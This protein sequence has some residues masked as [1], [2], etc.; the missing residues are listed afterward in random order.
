M[1]NASTIA[2][3]VNASD[4][5]LK[6]GEYPFPDLRIGDVEPA[7]SRDHH[8]LPRLDPMPNIIVTSPI[9]GETV[10]AVP[11][12]TAAE[13]RAAFAFA[14]RVQKSWAATPVSRRKEILLRYHDL[15]LDRQEELMDLIQAESGKNR[16]S[17][18]E[19]ILDQ[20]LTA[21]HYAY[22]AEKLLRPTRARGAVPVM[23]QVR[24]EHPPVGVVGMIAPWNYPLVLTASDALAAL[25]AGNA[26]VL[27]PDA[28]VPLSALRVAELL[29]EAGL[30]EGLFH[31]MTGS[32]EDVGQAIVAQC[33]YLMFTG[34]TRTGRKLAAQAAER[35]VGFSAELGGKNPMIVAADADIGKAARGAVTACFSNGGQLCISIERIYVHESVAAEFTRQFL[36]HTK[37]MKIGAGRD[38]RIELGSLISAAHRSKVEHMVDDAV[39]QGAR[40]LSGGRALPELG[41]AFYAPTVLVDVPPTATL[42]REEVF[43]PVVYLETVSSAAEAVA[44]ANDTDYGLNA[45]VWAK[46][47]TGRALASQ[48]QAGT[49]NINEG[50]AAAWS[51]MDAPMGGWK[52]SGVGRRHGAEGLLKYTESRTVAV[53][54]F[55]PLSGP[56]GVD[57]GRVAEVYRTA[58]KLGKRLLR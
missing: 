33:D 46:P 37:A 14:R 7:R 24:V 30:P 42:Y 55:L 51:S 21:R 11:A 56:V 23:T 1:K 38:W 34:S 15:V 2:H 20:A 3:Q 22:A 40:V 17:A 52:A 54:R 12:H 47:A 28:Q 27:K 8:A 41:P 43:G 25:L 48:L 50:F 19:E 35:L 4:A 57:R 44:R 9:T 13:T 49:V 16:A 5:G 32:A 18:H 53:Q 58:L 26:V 45:S 39:A 10:G 36:A 6:P 29:V 31:V